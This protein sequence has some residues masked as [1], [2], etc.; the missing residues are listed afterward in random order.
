MLLFYNV[1]IAVVIHAA[2][3]NP[4][5]HILNLLSFVIPIYKLIPKKKNVITINPTIILLFLITLQRY[6]FYF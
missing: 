1:N 5:V 6:N 2:A 4:D 3:Q